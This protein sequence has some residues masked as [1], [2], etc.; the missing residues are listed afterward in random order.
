[1]VMFRL[2]LALMVFSFSVSKAAEKISDGMVSIY[3]DS[4]QTVNSD[5]MMEFNGNVVINFNQ[6]II[7]T[8]KVA[9]NFAVVDGKK[10]I[11]SAI[12]SSAI[13]LI[14]KTKPDEII[15]ADQA[16]Y[17]LA[18]KTIKMNDNVKMKKGDDLVVVEH[19]TLLLK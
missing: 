2:I 13:K 4:M 9:I 8:N 17:C 6:Y 15:L 19:F 18:S 1:M 7:H 10:K 3:S 12:M 14:N 16:E 11:A 5:E